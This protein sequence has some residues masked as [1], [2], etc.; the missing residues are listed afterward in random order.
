MGHSCPKV[1]PGIIRARG[2]LVFVI[3][4]ECQV[5][6][7]G[8]HLRPE[9][10]TAESPWTRPVLLVDRENEYP[11]PKIEGALY[12][13]QLVHA[14]TR[15]TNESIHPALQGIKAETEDESQ[16]RATTDQVLGVTL[17]LAIVIVLVMM[18]ACYRRVRI[19]NW[20]Q[21]SGDDGVNRQRFSLKSWKIGRE[22][23]ST[24]ALEV[25]NQDESVN[26]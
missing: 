25:D 1:P 19:W 16:A 11:M 14:I 5:T 6:M 18:L 20:I 8:V 26:K 13:K 12:P 7:D 4:R 22:E 24:S 2:L 23:P 15:L 21:K 3:G 10:Q 9:D 17:F